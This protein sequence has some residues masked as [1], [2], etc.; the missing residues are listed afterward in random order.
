MA[1]KTRDMNE[2]DSSF[3]APAAKISWLVDGNPKRP[4]GKAHERFENY[5]GTDSVQGYLDAGGTKG[6]LRYDWQ[7]QF[8][9]IEAPP[10]VEAKKVEMAKPAK[11]AKNGKQQELANAETAD[12]VVNALLS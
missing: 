2:W 8:L 1:T 3:A 7:H 6:D 12:D 11:Q 5:F 4:H 9:D 10:K